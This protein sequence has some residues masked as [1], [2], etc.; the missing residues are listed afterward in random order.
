MFAEFNQKRSNPLV[1]YESKHKTDWKQQVKG[2]KETPM[3]W[4]DSRNFRGQVDSNAIK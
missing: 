3:I 2:L 4:N 1:L